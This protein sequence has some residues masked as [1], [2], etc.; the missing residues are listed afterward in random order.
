MP[1]SGKKIYLTF[2]DGP[3]PELTDWIAGQLAT[4][5]IK[6]TFFCVGDNVVKNP[7]IYK[8]LQDAGHSLGNH[9]HNH[10]KGFYTG[11]EAYFENV[12]ACN[13]VMQTKLFRPPYGQLKFSQQ[14]I[15]AKKYKI[16]MWD[17]LSYDY[18][19]SITPE[20]CLQNAVKYTR[21]GSIIVF[22]DNIKAEKN[23]TYALPR[24]ID[25][26]LDKGFEFDR[27]KA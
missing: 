22:H 1:S 21:P 3:I 25:Q 14:R 12:E 7:A 4:Y 24:A 6:A 16:I 23:V 26:L 27:I 19:H 9:T 17:I 5:N 8:R 13:A 2:D 20:K 18:S 10:I 15:L 11:N